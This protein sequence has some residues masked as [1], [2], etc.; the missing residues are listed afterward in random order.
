MNAPTKTLNKFYRSNNMDTNAAK[1]YVIEDYTHSHRCLYFTGGEFASNKQFAKNFNTRQ[2]AEVALRDI[3]DSH[4]FLT[5]YDI[6]IVRA[7]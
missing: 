7:K 3:R 2:D 6:R 4:D 5:K 1:G